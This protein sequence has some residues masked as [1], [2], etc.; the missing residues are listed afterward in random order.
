VDEILSL[1]YRLGVK[2]ASCHSSSN[3]CHYSFAELIYLMPSKNKRSTDPSDYQDLPQAIAAISKS[4]QDGFVIPAH[5]HRRDQLLYATH[6]IMRLRTA[7]AA[8][9]VP[10][11]SAVYIPSGTTHS[12]SM[13]SNVD[14]RS[15]YIDSGAISKTPRGLTVLAVSSLFRELILALIDEPV[16]YNSDSRGHSI[17]K[18][19]EWE[20]G[21]A[22]ELSLNYPLPSDPRLQRLC[23]GLL[24]NPADRRT[25]EDWSEVA[26]ASTR[27]L[28]RLFDRELGMS[29]NRWRQRVR[30]HN[31][32]EA[33]A[34]GEAVASVAHQ[35]GYQSPSAFSAAFAKVM[36]QSPS[37]GFAN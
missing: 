14:M 11:D 28:A 16:D 26:G 31:A 15:L 30:F 10:R 32:L 6:G 21:R 12:I 3:L 9:I 17:A 35:H 19:I 24:A 25:L 20:I 8:W 22:P 23:A 18:M 4:Y 29:F 27:T 37:K 13:H 2:A 34:R 33:L 7:R 1:Q 5:E 36:G